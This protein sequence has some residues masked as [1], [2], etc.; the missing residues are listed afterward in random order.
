MAVLSLRIFVFR[1]TL[2][3]R[4]KEPEEQ[5]RGRISSTWTFHIFTLL[6]IVLC[7]AFT[8]VIYKRLEGFIVDDN[9]PTD[10]QPR[11]RR[12]SATWRSRCWLGRNVLCIIRFSAIFWS[13]DDGV[14]R[15][16]QWI[17]SSLCLW[18]SC[19]CNNTIILGM[20]RRCLLLQLQ[21]KQIIKLITLLVKC[22]W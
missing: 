16:Q 20:E 1:T 5:Y 10:T 18:L 19:Q 13:K 3:R 17:P 12:R 22:C 6:R 15:R 2:R 14:F 8:V 21:L 11:R 9:T 7:I 4:R